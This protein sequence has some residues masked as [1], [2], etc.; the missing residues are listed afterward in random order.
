[1]ENILR[2]TVGVID[3]AFLSRI[4]DS[5]VGA[6]S[7]SSQY[8]TLIQI[9][10]TALSAGSIVCINQA[11]GMKNMKRVDRLATI[12]M[13]VNILLGLLVGALCL[14]GSSA[15]LSIVTLEPSSMDAAVLYLR[16]V[17]GCSLFQC[18]EIVAAGLCRS[19]GRPNAPLII[20][21]TENGINIIG[22]YIA[23]FHGKEL[24]IDP[25]AGVAW[26]TVLSRFTGMVLSTIIAH[27]THVRIS[28]KLLY[29]F[30]REDLKLTLSIAIPSG[31]NNIAYSMGQ[32]VTTA[33]ISM[34]GEIMMATKVYMNNIAH[35]V[36]LVGMSAG[37]ASAILVGYKIGAG[38]FGEA[39]R[40]RRLVTVIGLISNLAF[41]LIFLLFRY[42]LL[43]IFTQDETIIRIGANLF[44]LD[45]VVEI[46]R[47]L[48]NTCSGALQA[49]GDIRYQMFVNQLSC[50]FISVG[51]SWL[52]GIVFHMNLYGVWIAFALDEMTRGLLLLR[53]WRSMKWLPGAQA[54][55]KII[56]K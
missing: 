46:G 5:V 36:S 14:W 33:I 43:S 9:I 35:Y 7:A 45:I 1:M 55:R 48:N 16:I 37:T 41:S 31:V 51:C 39:N 10:A 44:F 11:I 12:A 53:R 56:A 38:E 40:I 3:V 24:G 47:S 50:W 15:L 19:M 27:R 21:L 30:P 42:P 25:L 20:N 52:F 26:A 29:P 32:I 22:N 54:R 18:V 4:S 8:L 17:G 28:P 49:T 6:V 23:V 2:A 13:A 34:T